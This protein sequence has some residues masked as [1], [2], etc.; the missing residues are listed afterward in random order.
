MTKVMLHLLSSAFTYGKTMMPFLMLLA[1]HDTNS[2]PIGI[3]WHLH[4]WYNMIPMPV[5]IVSHNQ[6]SHIKS[7][8]DCL[9]LRSVMVKLRMLMSLCDA[10]TSA[11]GMTWQENPCC[12]SFQSSWHNKCMGAVDNATT[13]MCCLCQCQWQHMA[14]SHVA[15]HFNH[16]DIRIGMVPLMMPSASYNTD[17]NANRPHDTTFQL[18]WPEEWNYMLFNVISMKTHIKILSWNPYDCGRKWSRNKENDI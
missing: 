9:Y 2:T 7:N 11:N 8:F 4:Q 3:I 5:A 6:K 17:T 18:S 14:K 10:N 16:F 15:P 12:T 1:S 13:I